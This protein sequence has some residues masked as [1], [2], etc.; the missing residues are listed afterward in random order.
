MKILFVCRANVGR[1]Q[2]AEAILNSLS[3][4]HIAT[5]AGLNP[6]AQWEGERLSKTQYVAPCMAEIG[7]DVSEKVSKRLIE[8]MVID[9]DKIVVIGER[10]N[11]PQFLT[12]SD[13]VM[14]WD[15]IDPDI[16]EM[17]LHRQVRDEIRKRIVEL[18]GDTRE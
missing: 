3:S 16:G 11:W 6:P 1:S 5:S 8:S 4:D 17:E 15:I 10:N 18:C 12:D 7:I 9:V 2:M 13:K 14:Y